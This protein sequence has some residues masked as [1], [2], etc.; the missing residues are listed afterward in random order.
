MSDNQLVANEQELPIEVKKNA[1]EI[2]APIIQY[3]QLDPMHYAFSFE[4]DDK[5]TINMEE[6][7]N[8][9]SKNDFVDIEFDESVPEDKK[10]YYAVAATSGALTGALSFVK[11]S[12]EQLSK[13]NEWKEKNWKPII[14]YAAELI[15][16]KKKDYK[17]ASKYLVNQAVKRIKKDEK[18]KEFTTLLTSHPT[19]AG[20]V[21]SL[22][23]QFSGKLCYINESGEISFEKTLKHYFI[24]KTNSEK[25]VAA[26][27]YWL[28]ELALNQIE[29][30]RNLI[31]NLGIPGGLL[32]MI[33][34][35]V[36]LP[37]FENIPANRDEAEELFSNWLKGIIEGAE[38]DVDVNSDKESAENINLAVRLMKIAL[39][40]SSDVF[41]VLIN[42]C[43]VRSLYLL[44]RIC[45]VVKCKQIKSFDELKEI[46]A[47][48]IVQMDERVLSRMC[49]ISS[50]SFVTLNLAGA[51]LKA[52][53]AQKA[54]DREFL[55]AFLAELNIPA[56]GRLIFACAKDS[57]YWGED[58]KIIFHRKNRKFAEAE[59]V[60]SSEFDDEAFTTLTFTPEQARILYCLENLV[61][62]Y[63]IEHT[64]DTKQAEKKALWLQNWRSC[65]LTGANLPPEME[66]EFFLEDEDRLYDG[67]Y[68]LS[69][70][71]NNYNWFYLF[72]QELSLFK[73]YSSLG[74]E[75]DDEFRKLKVESDYVSSQ[76]IRRQ[77]VVSQK[78]LDVIQ[79]TYKGY[80]D[81]MTGKV[82]KTIAI[83]FG[84]AAATALTGGLALAYAPAIAA[85]IAG[86]AV[87]GL[88]GAALAS[89][90]LAF[91]GGGS[92]AAGGLG[93]AG[94]TAIITGGGALLG[95][96]GSSSTSAVVALMTTN[97][98]Y[99][100]RQ[101]AKILT[102]C[103]CTLCDTLGQKQLVNT[104]LHQVELTINNT[105]TELD[106]LKK[107]DNDLDKEYIKRIDSY[108]DCLEKVQNELKKMVK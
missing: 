1:D 31:D 97:D 93:M 104:L 24:G 29:S 6:S 63:D 50:A 57:K 79:K 53:A 35:F 44:I 15:G 88:H 48:E 80:I 34:V 66:S 105:S 39:N 70:D 76:F 27:M 59:F 58:I 28:F 64:K 69:K 33:K 2:P 23:T 74:C 84:S 101:S 7:E 21:F 82:K 51:A 54:G 52:L 47:S 13:V 108:L 16:C 10:V 14:I 99:W 26:I 107:E 102:H 95:L 18:A 89:A 77:T 25:I 62:R 19:T 45:D 3:N 78:E 75:Y 9:S 42:E 65:I 11:L 60:D 32:K 103:K 49:F 12:E 83:V 86:E 81:H 72:T 55:S 92:L 46:P 87:V 106:V 96:A 98:D 41:P 30:K 43:V 17:S 61:V 36:N 38:L 71:K 22:I 85:M 73:P 100:I 40:L 56:I 8:A 91:V 5:F 20:L 90:S 37:F 94:G 67:F 68:E 4:F